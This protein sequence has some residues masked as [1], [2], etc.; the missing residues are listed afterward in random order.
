[1]KELLRKLLARLILGRELYQLWKL[2][3]YEEEE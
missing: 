2:D 1:M 3:Y